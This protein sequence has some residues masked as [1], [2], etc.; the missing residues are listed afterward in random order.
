M[1]GR[2]L[3]DIDQMP[4]LG[5]RIAANSI[6]IRMAQNNSCFAADN[7]EVALEV[8]W[9][10]MNRDRKMMGR[11]WGNSERS[12]DVWDGCRKR[13]NTDRDGI[14]CGA[15]DND[16]DRSQDPG[17]ESHDIPHNERDNSRQAVMV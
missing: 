13:A 15:D 2:H 1:T 3:I 17:H 7:S 11:A 4:A 5:S 10:V 6:A 9:P 12:S 14:H 16:T 8:R